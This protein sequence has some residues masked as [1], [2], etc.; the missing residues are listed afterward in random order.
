MKP[1]ERIGVA[2][3]KSQRAI[4]ITKSQII[5]SRLVEQL[6]CH[7]EIGCASCWEYGCR[8]NVVRGF[9][10]ASGIPGLHA[11]CWN[12]FEPWVRNS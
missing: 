3:P 7:A 4:K 10:S 5:F 11:G 2:N 8:T 6:L 12:A 9:S 1:S